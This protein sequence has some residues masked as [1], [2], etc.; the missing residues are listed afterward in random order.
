M[1]LALVLGL[2]PCGSGLSAEPTS[3]VDAAPKL[4]STAGGKAETWSDIRELEAAAAPLTLA[5]DL[6]DGGADGDATPAAPN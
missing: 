4:L 6:N 1:F 3:S 5:I 2:A